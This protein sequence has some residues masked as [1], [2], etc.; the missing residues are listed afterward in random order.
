[1]INLSLGPSWAEK[2]FHQQKTS[3]S[4][5]GGGELSSAP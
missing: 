5:L 3:N 1:M 4:S 2:S